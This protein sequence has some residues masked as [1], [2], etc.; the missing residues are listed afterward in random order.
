MR[1]VSFKTKNSPCFIPNLNSCVGYSSPFFHPH[2]SIQTFQGSQIRQIWHILCQNCSDDSTEVTE[3]VT[4]TPEIF[5][6]KQGATS[7]PEIFGNK[8]NFVLAFFATITITL[9]VNIVNLNYR[10]KSSKL[11]NYTA[12]QSRKWVNYDQSLFNDRHHGFELFRSAD[13]HIYFVLSLTVVYTCQ[14]HVLESLKMAFVVVILHSKY[15][16]MTPKF[17]KQKSQ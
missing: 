6:N 11:K 9:I 15:S 13:H 3:G 12:R 7:T 1:M 17:V 10:G 8:H 16:K 5:S 2:A 4:S 14:D